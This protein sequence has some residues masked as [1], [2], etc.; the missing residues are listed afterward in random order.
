[1]YK[2]VL[3]FMLVAAISCKK[4]AKNSQV[5]PQAD[6]AGIVGQWTWVSSNF[7]FNYLTP[8]SGVHK[9]LTFTATGVLYITHNDSTDYNPGPYV[10]VPPVSPLVLFPG[11]VTD[12]LAYHFGAEPVGCPPQDDMNAG[13]TFMALVIGGEVNQFKIS[14]D[15]LYLVRPPCLAQPDSVVY[16]RTN[17]AP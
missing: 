13:S 6:T 7:L 10:A 17:S 2:L 8:Q 9:K 14:N 5:V 15:T 3:A 16:V 11:D 12:T 1:M 4:E